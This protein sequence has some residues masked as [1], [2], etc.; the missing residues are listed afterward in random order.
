MKYGG[1]GV[2]LKYLGCEGIRRDGATSIPSSSGPMS[3][4]ISENSF[5]GDSEMSVRVWSPRYSSMTRLVVS[6][7][8]TSTMADARDTFFF[9]KLVNFAGLASLELLCGDRCTWCSAE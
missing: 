1:S 7:A 2:T 4:S 3:V 8:S 5:I 9:K 6:S